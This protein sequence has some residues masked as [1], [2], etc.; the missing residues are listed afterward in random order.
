MSGK[1]R[2]IMAPIDEAS[3]SREETIPSQLGRT[4]LSKRRKS[5]LEKK[6]LSGPSSIRRNGQNMS[7][8][9]P[10]LKRLRLPRS[11]SYKEMYLEKL[12]DIEEQTLELN[13]NKLCPHRYHC[14][15]NA[16]YK[17]LFRSFAS[18]YV[19]KTTLS[20]VRVLF[21]KGRINAESLLKIYLGNDAI[22]FAQYV[23]VQ[24]WL[25]KTILCSLRHIFKRRDPLFNGIAGFFSSVALLLDVP[26]RRRTLALYCFVRAVNDFI[27]VYGWRSIPGGVVMEFA[28]TQVPIMYCFAQRPKCLDKAYYR[29]ILSMGNIKGEKF[30]D[31]LLVPRDPIKSCEGVVHPNHSCCY[32]NTEDWLGPGMLRAALMYIPVH[33]LPPILFTPEKIVKE[34]TSYLKRKT[35]NTLRSALFLSTYQFVMKMGMCNGRSFLGKDEWSVPAV[36]GFACGLSLAIEH[37]HRRREL[38][39]YTLPRALEAIARMLPRQNLFGELIRW[40]HMSLFLY[41]VAIGCWT[42]AIGEHGWNGRINSLNATVLKVAFGSK[43]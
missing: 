26:E 31:L 42:Y 27:Q 35:V 36:S 28:L 15:H 9:L 32:E 29:W 20:L 11:R 1:K 33:F 16:L 34:P 38:L 13:K 25:F 12:R 37:P 30:Q 8:S 39:L 22:K 6:T 43:H 10:D 7:V 23:A 19:M 14:V 41:S 4:H 5:S 40:K 24:S 21:G 2:R 17:G 3:P 18:A